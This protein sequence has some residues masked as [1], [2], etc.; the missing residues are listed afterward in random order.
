MKRRNRIISLLLSGALMLSLAA[1]GAT[2]GEGTPSPSITPSAS[3][4]AQGAFTDGTY[5][6]SANGNNG[7]IEVSVTVENGNITDVT[8]VSHEE[9]AGISDPA[10]E[11]IPKAIV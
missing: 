5:T 6:G 1:C 3:A 2:A 11:D 4:P 10:L 8:I 7:P 9:T